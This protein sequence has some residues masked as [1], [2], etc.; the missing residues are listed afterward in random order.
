VRHPA[1][2]DIPSLSMKL[3]RSGGHVGAGRIRRQ[4]SRW[5]VSFRTRL[6]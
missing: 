2:G 6:G 1:E 3:P 4:G 5:G